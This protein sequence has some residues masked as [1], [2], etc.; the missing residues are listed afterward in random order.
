MKPRTSRI[1]DAHHDRLISTPRRRVDELFSAHVV[2]IVQKFIDSIRRENL[3]ETRTPQRGPT[4][5]SE[6]AQNNHVV[7]KLGDAI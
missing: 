4:R 1:D 5:E 2:S 7:I 3:L 6:G